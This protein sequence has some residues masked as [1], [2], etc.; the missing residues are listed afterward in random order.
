MGVSRKL[1]SSGFEEWENPWKP[2]AATP[3]LVAA[4]GTVGWFAAPHLFHTEHVQPLM[5]STTAL[6][7]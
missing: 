7:T 2:I 6:L 1:L 3:L 4:G 5:A